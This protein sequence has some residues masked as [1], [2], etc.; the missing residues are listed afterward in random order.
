M[1]KPFQAIVAIVVVM[2]AAVIFETRAHAQV[3]LEKGVP[4]TFAVGE[5]AVVIRGPYGDPE[6][7]GRTTYLYFPHNTDPL[8]GITTDQLIALLTTAITAQR[9]VQF[10]LDGCITNPVWSPSPYVKVRHRVQLF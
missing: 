10:I 3:L 2:T 6:N 1:L 9:E 7:C 4:W 8:V 5:N